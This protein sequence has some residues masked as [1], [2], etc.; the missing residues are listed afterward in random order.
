[1]CGN[2]AHLIDCLACHLLH[3]CLGLP[4]S[5]SSSSLQPHTK[6]HCARSSFLVCRSRSPT[7]CSCIVDRDCELYMENSTSHTEA[8]TSKDAPSQFSGANVHNCGGACNGITIKQTQMVTR[9]LN[10]VHPKMP[11]PTPNLSNSPPP[12]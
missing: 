11:T 2:R 10:T 12:T 6:F 8:P 9:H 5:V 1:M 7:T 3:V 4:G